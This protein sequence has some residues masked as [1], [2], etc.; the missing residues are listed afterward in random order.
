MSTMS[1]QHKESAGNDTDERPVEYVVVSRGEGGKRFHEPAA[2]LDPETDD[3][4]PACSTGNGHDLNWNWRRR[5]GIEVWKD[6]CNRECADIRE[7]EDQ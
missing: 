5:D 3:A 1:T 6:P 2:G 7:G 4:K